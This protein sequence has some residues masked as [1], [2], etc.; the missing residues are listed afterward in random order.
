MKK[1]YFAFILMLINFCSLGQTKN[2]TINH[3]KF[4]LKSPQMNDEWLK[5]VDLYRGKKKLLSHTLYKEDGDCSLTTIQL[6][7]YSVEKNNIIFYSY[8]ASTDRMPLNLKFGFQKQVYSV[9]DNGTVKPKSSK[10]YIED[11][12]K[13]TNP[14]FLIE[15]SWTHKG[16]AYLNKAP[17]TDEEKMWLADYIKSAEKKYKAKFVLGKERQALEKEVRE[18]LKDKIEEHTKNWD[19]Y[20]ETYGKSRK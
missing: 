2:Y 6:G 16:L 15:H 10:I 13:T 3:H 1:L 14:D 9:T 12:V 4:S 7:D 18:K 19:I 17:I 8:W 5:T 11:V 20:K